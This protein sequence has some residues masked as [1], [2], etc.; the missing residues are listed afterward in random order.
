[1][2]PMSDDPMAWKLS[3][4]F[5]LDP[6]GEIGLPEYFLP[7]AE[8]LSAPLQQPAPTADPSSSNIVE[9][10]MQLETIPPEAAV[11]KAKTLTKSKKRKNQTPKLPKTKKQGN[12]EPVR[13]YFGSIQDKV[14]MSMLIFVTD[15]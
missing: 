3:D 10:P 13:A 5:V 2:D 11:N 8:A 4:V 12:E 1:M 14:K 15:E 9:T 6:F 7:V